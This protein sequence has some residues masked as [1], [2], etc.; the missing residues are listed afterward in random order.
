M[1][2]YLEDDAIYI[3]FDEIVKSTYG[4]HPNFSGEREGRTGEAEPVRLVNNLTSL[5]LFFKLLDKPIRY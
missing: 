4:N 5:R 3:R 1:R 2:G